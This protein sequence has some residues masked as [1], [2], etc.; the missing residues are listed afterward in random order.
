MLPSDEA[1]KRF[2]NLSAVCRYFISYALSQLLCVITDFQKVFNAYTLRA[3]LEVKQHAGREAALYRSI[4][5]ALQSNSSQTV[6]RIN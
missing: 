6:T 4:F 1:N 2:P 3:S 5:I